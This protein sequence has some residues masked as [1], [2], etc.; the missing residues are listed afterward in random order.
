MYRSKTCGELSLKHQKEMVTLAGWVQSLRDF[1]KLTFLD[2]RDRHGITQVVFNA[3]ENAELYQEAHGLNREFVIQIKGEVRERENK[4]LNNPTG[5]IEIRVV[6][7]TILNPSE[8]PPFTII[9]ETDGSEELRLKY[10]YLDLRRPKMNKLLVGRAKLFSV[11]RRYL[12]SRDFL[13]IETPILIKSTPEGARDFLVPSRIQPGSF[14]AL[15]QSPQI[16]KQILMVSGADRYYQIVKCFRDEDFRG[17]RQPEF[18]QLDC[19]MSFVEQEDVL[20]TFEGLVKEVYKEMMGI[21]NIQI[22]RMTY[23]DAVKFYG[24]DK[25]D[26][27]F[28]C[29]IIEISSH[30]PTSEF[31]VFSQSISSGGVVSGI[32]AANGASFT[33]KQIDAAIDF[34]KESN[35]GLQGLVWIRHN[36]EGWKSS[37]DKF[38]TP[39]QLA[40]MGKQLGM[41]K[42]D[43]AFLAADKVS[44]V[45]KSLGD[46]RLKLA[47]ENGWIDENKWSI[48]WILDFPLFEQDEET[49]ETHF[50]HHPFCM[51]H[52]EDIQYLESDPLRVRGQLYD[53]VINGNG[54]LSGSIRIHQKELQ[55]RIFK[56]LGLSE[57]EKMDKFGFMLNAFQYGA[58]PHGGCAFG[59][60]RW[61]MLMLGGDTIR[62][63]IPFPKASNGKDMMMNAPTYVD[64]DQLVE[65]GIEVMKKEDE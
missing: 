36:E 24:S 54:I 52:Q 6:E 60:D 57:E 23:A 10:R 15:P 58:P 41:N 53:L 43:L 38:Y 39:E 28:D 56:I 64:N 3:E 59:I 19:E 13:E 33:R 12:D 25:P 51:P 21:E 20:T 11:M 55:D 48:L 44:K 18:T 17:D 7:L 14:Y 47:K 2:L 32:V 62:D 4:N 49:G 8:I 35:R 29:K 9:D 61:L 31:P 37:V 45:Q 63:V 65:L 5:E 26:L 42:G 16:L 27:R 50:V 30:I 34:V 1:G 22:D 46:L 40:E